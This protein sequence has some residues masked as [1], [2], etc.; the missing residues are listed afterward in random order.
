MLFRKVKD[1]FK[2]ISV[3][4]NAWQYSDWNIIYKK[5]TN[6]IRLMNSEIHSKSKIL[7]YVQKSR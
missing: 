7:F 2:E 4:Y 6:Y 1:D 3:Y 5:L